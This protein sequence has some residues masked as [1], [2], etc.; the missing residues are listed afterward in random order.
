MPSAAS[1]TAFIG[2]ARHLLVAGFGLDAVQGRPDPDRALTWRVQPGD[3]SA[4]FCEIRTHG[5]PSSALRIGLCSPDGTASGLLALAP[6]Q[7]SS[8]MAGGQAVARMY[9]VPARALGDGVESPAHYVLV[10]APT[11]SHALDEACAPAGAWRIALRHDGDA[12]AHVSLQIQRDDGLREKMVSINRV[13]KVVKGGRILG[14]AALTV[15]GDGDGGIGMGKGK[16]REVPVAVQK[17]MED[18][19]IQMETSILE[20]GRMIRL[21]GV[22]SIFLQMGL[23]TKETGLKIRDMEKVKKFG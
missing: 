5:L 6:G 15:V 8:L 11:Q 16:S 4:N 12:A 22:E 9:H 7:G 23:F 13:T 20:S 21:M 10:T 14:F 3:H 2:V 17:A 1:N 19:I 18:C